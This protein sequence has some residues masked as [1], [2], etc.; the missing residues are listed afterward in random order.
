MVLTGGFAAAGQPPPSEERLRDAVIRIERAASALGEPEAV[1]RL[2]DAF[3][4]SARMVTDLHDE[5]LDF[6]EVA[7]VLTLA[8]ASQAKPEAILSLWATG[9]L[10]WSE[11]ADRNRVDRRELLKRL[12]GVRRALT[13]PGPASSPRRSPP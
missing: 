9:R 4:V 5:K 12:E 3:K 6:G 8:E 7:M 11:I 10:S 13:Q 1:A 2:A